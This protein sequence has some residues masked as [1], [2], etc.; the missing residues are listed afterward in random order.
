MDI[1]RKTAVQ[2]QKKKTAV[3]KRKKHVTVWKKR[4]RR[5]NEFYKDKF[6]GLVTFSNK[7]TIWENP[8]QP[9]AVA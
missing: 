5:S 2:F 4:K 7:G 9:L 3:R 8:A 6:D 1:Q